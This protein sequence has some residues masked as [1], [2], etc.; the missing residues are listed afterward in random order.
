MSTLKMKNTKKKKV[1]S[2]IREIIEKVTIPND[3]EIIGNGAFENC[4]SLK[5]LTIPDSVTSIG[6]WAF[7]ECL[8][9]ESI[10]IDKEKDSLDLR[11]AE[12]PKTTKVY[13]RGEF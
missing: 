10:Y 3:I 8:S 4:T 7:E 5:E 6:N 12:I 9:L 1:L 2:N 13:W 11:Y